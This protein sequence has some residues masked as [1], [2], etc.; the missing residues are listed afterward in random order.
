MLTTLRNIIAIAL[1]LLEASTAPLV[2]H[3]RSW[4][5]RI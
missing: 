5:L 3:H 1:Y 2:I 4:I